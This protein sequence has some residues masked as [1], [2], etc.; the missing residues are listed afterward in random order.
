MYDSNGVDKGI[1]HNT[2]RHIQDCRP[3]PVQDPCCQE[4]QW[5]METKEGLSV[6]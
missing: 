6:D 4:I 1:D 3:Q 2:R 5:R